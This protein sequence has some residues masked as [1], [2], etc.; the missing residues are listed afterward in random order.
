MKMQGALLNRVERSIHMD[1]YQLL[2]VARNASFADVT[3]AYRK[4]A[5]IYHPDVNPD[6]PDI[7][8]S[9]KQITE[10]FEILT[11]ANKRAIYNAKHPEKI[12]KPKSRA[13]KKAETV[14]GTDPN[15]GSHTIIDV[16]QPK[17]DVWGQPIEEQ[18]DIRDPMTGLI[19]KRG[20]KKF[21]DSVRYEDNGPAPEIR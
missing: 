18:E 15:L 9:F 7:V 19:I 14:W 16:P 3:A 21:K 1:H 17:Y 8:K 11:D 6:K 4:L 10:A 12:Q 5:K 13:Q 20:F 2:G